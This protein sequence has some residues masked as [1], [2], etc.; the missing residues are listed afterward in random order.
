MKPPIITLAPSGMSAAASAAEIAMRM[1]RPSQ[2]MLW[3]PASIEDHVSKSCF[4][5]ALLARSAAT[6]SPQR[7]R[8]SGGRGCKT[9]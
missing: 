1:V 2:P 3:G 8:P 7:C 5:A 4:D 9:H 6:P